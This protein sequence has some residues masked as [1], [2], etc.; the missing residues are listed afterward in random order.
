[1]LNLG[2][3]FQ[4][5]FKD[6]DVIKPDSDLYNNPLGV[7]VIDQREELRSELRSL[8]EDSRFKHSKKYAEQFF[9]SLP[10]EDYPRLRLFALHLFS[11]FGSSYQCECSFSVMN[12]IKSKESAS[13]TE[14]NL[15]A[16]MRIGLTEMTPDIDALVENYFRRQNRTTSASDISL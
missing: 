9:G 4:G 1:M 11:M 10:E 13:L 8:K 15:S 7:N 6:V 2:K 14:K 3:E 5:R 12:Y 16:L